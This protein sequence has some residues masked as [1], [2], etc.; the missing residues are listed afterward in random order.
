MS[1]V[2]VDIFPHGNGSVDPRIF[3]YPDPGSKNVA[4]PIDP[5]PKH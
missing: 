3:A 5:D 2:F 4:D 1:A